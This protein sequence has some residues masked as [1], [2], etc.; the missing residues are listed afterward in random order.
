MKRGIVDFSI[1]P[2]IHWYAP[3]DKDSIDVVLSDAARRR[4][5]IRAKLQ[6]SS[7][8]DED[9]LMVIANQCRTADS[10]HGI[11]RIFNL[12]WVH[13]PASVLYNGGTASNQPKTAGRVEVACVAGAVPNASA[14]LNL[15][16]TVVR[17]ICV[18]RHYVASVDGDFTNFANTHAQSCKRV[19]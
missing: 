1:M 7:F 10:A 14:H 3:H 16:C 4:S 15:A 6:L 11:N 12:E 18:P 17:S 9:A 2:F 19:G 8:D 13:S 5:A